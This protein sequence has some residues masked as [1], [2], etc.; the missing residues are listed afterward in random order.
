MIDR[1]AVGQLD[2][3]QEFDPS[4]ML[5]AYTQAIVPGETS[6]SR[7]VGRREAAD[8]L[9]RRGDDNHIVEVSRAV[10]NVVFC[11]STSDT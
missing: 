10:E 9:R 1:T 2:S 4:G 11:R 3:L 7:I 6:I 5:Y 8:R